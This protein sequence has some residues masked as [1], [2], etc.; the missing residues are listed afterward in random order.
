MTIRKRQ[1]RT[2][3]KSIN[4]AGT[5]QQPD[6]TSKS[7]RSRL[8]ALEELP[9][10]YQE[11]E[12]EYIKHGYR[13]ETKSTWSCL[14][15][16]TYVHNESINIYSHLIAAVSFLAEL[17]A[18]DYLMK[19]HFPGASQ[20]DRLVFAAFLATAVTALTLSSLY[21]TFICH[22][23][24]VSHLWLKLDFVGIVSLIFGGF[25]SGIYVGFYCDPGL[26]KVYWSMVRYSRKARRS[27]ADTIRQ[28]S[29]LSTLSAILV[30]HPRLQGRR[31]RTLRAMVFIITG[32]SGFAPVIHGV[33]RYGWD[34]AWQQTGMPYYLLEGLLFI[35]G[36]AVYTTRVPEK[37]KPGKFDIW[38]SSHQIFHVLVAIAT[39]VH[40]VGIWQ[41]FEFHYQHNR[42]CVHR[43]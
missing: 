24:H 6:S 21:H 42:Q 35:I 12:N 2:A 26:Q 13:P 29:I 33:V 28:I 22:S 38:G 40:F 37:L 23:L 25:L 9:I 17:F 3:D 15:S 31:W 11:S 16:W 36:S 41:A 27:E 5:V 1:P 18:I 30:L 7:R 10:W 19:A 32:L 34:Q 39:F 43:I 14:V 20:Q 8:Y 4:G